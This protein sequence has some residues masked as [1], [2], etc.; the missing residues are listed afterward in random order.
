M[1][2]VEVL[3]N[4]PMA[5][6]GPQALARGLGFV[7]EGCVPGRAQGASPEVAMLLAW[8]PCVPS[9]PLANKSAEVCLW[10]SS[11]DSPPGGVSHLL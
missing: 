4:P 11:D 5:A 3:L 2:G 8:S 10:I 7:Q 9:A 6:M 1:E